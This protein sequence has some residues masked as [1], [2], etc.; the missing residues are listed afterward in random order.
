M[1][2]RD[3]YAVGRWASIVAASAVALFAALLAV[4]LTGHHTEMLSYGTCIILA[5][6]FVAMMA[7]V[8]RWA[9]REK[10]VWSQ[11][12]LSFAIMYAVL[13]SACYYTQ[14][15]VVRAGAALLSREA[16]NL[17]SFNAGSVMFAVDMLG[18]TLMALS[19]WFAAPVFTGAKNG[20][21]LSRLC[22]IHGLLAVPTVVYPLLMSAPQGEATTRAVRLG[23]IALLAWCAVFI[24]IPLLLASLFGGRAVR[25]EGGRAKPRG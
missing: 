19:T 21:W 14:L 18:Y 1:T 13:V 2:G 12:S 24:P 3:T 11:I 9:P 4:G 6:G 25:R 5:W 23:S 10:R 17:L 22:T 15:T 8:N 20:L 7:S 16:L